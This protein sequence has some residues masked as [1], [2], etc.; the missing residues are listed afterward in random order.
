MEGNIGDIEKETFLTFIE[1]QLP[2]IAPSAR[3]S[4]KKQT[5]FQLLRLSRKVQEKPLFC[6]EEKHLTPVIHTFWTEVVWRELWTVSPDG[7][8]KNFRGEVTI[9]TFCLRH[10]LGFS[11]VTMLWKDRAWWLWW[12]SCYCH[13]TGWIWPMRLAR[14]WFIS[15]HSC[16]LI[17]HAFCPLPPTLSIFFLVSFTYYVLTD[18]QTFVHPSCSHWKVLY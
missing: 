17:H 18:F 9:R 2:R 7:V 16:V 15:L 14:S 13:T 4:Q 1:C 10:K 5:L 11:R 12:L 8:R 6:W 3:E